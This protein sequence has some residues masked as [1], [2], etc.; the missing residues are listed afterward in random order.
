M[1]TTFDEDL[2][3]EISW[4]KFE[5]SNLF[6]LVKTATEDA[7][8]ICIRMF[9]VMLY[10][11]WEGFIKHATQK[12]FKHINKLNLTAS[13]LNCKFARQMF[14]SKLPQ[15]ID[16]KK[17][18]FFYEI[19]NN[20]LSSQKKVCKLQEKVDTKSNLTKEIFEDILLLVDIDN[21]NY[22]T[23][24]NFINNFL[25]MRNH[26]A[27]GDRDRYDFFTCEEIYNNIL[28][29]LEQYKKDITD[30]FYNKKFKTE[31][32]YTNDSVHSYRKFRLF[33]RFRI[34]NPCVSCR[35]ALHWRHYI[36]KH[37]E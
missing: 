37:Y 32:K 15:L 26:I 6:L 33:S 34:I 30:N 23:K 3:A 20:F 8:Q 16:A 21:I 14:S 5:L 29:L 9:I 18:R 11:H 4:R 35:A 12:Y 7:Q 19:Y 24:L 22:S 17:N 25:E 2:D 13:Q 36:L 28:N 10:A 1:G 31:Q 27:H